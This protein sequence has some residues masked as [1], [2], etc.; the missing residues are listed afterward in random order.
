[1]TEEGFK[2]KLTA[3]LSADVVGYS[4]LMGD[5]EEATIRTLT[6]YREAMDSLIQLHRGRVVDSIGDNL[7]A[8]FAS[9]VDAVNCAVEIQ[10]ELAERN[11]ELADDR[12][13]EFRIGVNVGDVVEEEDRIYGDGVNIAARVEG[14]ANA[15]G[16]CISG[17]V[18][19]HVENK[20]ALE[21]EFIGEQK[22]KNIIRPVRL[23]RVCSFEGD[24]TG[25][26]DGDGP[27]C[28]ARCRCHD[29][30]DNRHSDKLGHPIRADHGSFGWSGPDV[31]CQRLAC[32]APCRA[33]RPGWGCLRCLR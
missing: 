25:F 22:V 30:H 24:A 16:I 28:R 19:E 21:Y 29:R 2:R 11:T 23:Y 10:K 4:R 5:N 6:N 33:Q 13:M 12:K 18:Y 15:G 8:E 32:L 1:M 3:I 9:A 31:L 26:P 20:L 17:R 27:P 14:L 7:L